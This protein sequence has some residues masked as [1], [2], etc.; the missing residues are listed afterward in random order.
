MSKNILSLEPKLS[1]E[2][3]SQ[4]SFNS[5]TLIE[6]PKGIS[7]LIEITLRSSSAKASEF[8]MP[9]SKSKNILMKISYYEVC[10]NLV[11]VN[12]SR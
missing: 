1:S 3:C 8:F 6:S 2:I 12:G 10:H 7:L 9:T 5:N 4:I 11:N